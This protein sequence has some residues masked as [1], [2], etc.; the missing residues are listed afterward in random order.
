MVQLCLYSKTVIPVVLHLCYLHSL[1]RILAL[2]QV[3]A[4]SLLLSEYPRTSVYR[5]SAPVIALG[6]HPAVCKA[7]TDTYDTVKRDV[8]QI[9]IRSGTPSNLSQSQLLAGV[10]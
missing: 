8:H 9:R 3:L 2:L 4:R 5:I 7:K 10:L 1:R 6:T